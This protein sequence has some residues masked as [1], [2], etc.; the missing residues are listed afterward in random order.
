MLI[1]HYDIMFNCSS[2]ENYARTH[3]VSRCTWE[4]SIR[5]FIS[6]PGASPPI[7]F[8]AEKSS[9]YRK[10]EV[11]ETRVEQFRVLDVVNTFTALLPSWRSLPPQRL[12]TAS[13]VQSNKHNRLVPLDRVILPF[14]RS[15]PIFLAS[16]TARIQYWIKSYVQL[17][18]IVYDEPRNVDK[19][20]Q[21][22]HIVLV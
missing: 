16:K 17:P 5:D 18:T 2:L 4:S 12:R 22:T 8:A 14:S 1:V 7:S 19:Y 3:G 13:Y 20:A 21:E 11:K 10:S 15:F 9:A 6:R